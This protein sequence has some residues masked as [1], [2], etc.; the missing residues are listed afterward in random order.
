MAQTTM[1]NNPFPQYWRQAIEAGYQYALTAQD[2]INGARTVLQ[3]AGYTSDDISALTLRATMTQAELNASQVKA[4]GQT[5]LGHNT[6]DD[7]CGCNGCKPA[8]I[9]AIDDCSTFTPIKQ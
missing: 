5:I 3:D 1:Q 9:P 8:A 4:F 6:A 2:N 7:D